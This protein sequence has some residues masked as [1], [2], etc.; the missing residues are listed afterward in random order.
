MKTIWIIALILGAFFSCKSTKC[1]T[2]KVGDDKKDAVSL[3]NTAWHLVSIHKVNIEEKIKL[4]YIQFDDSVKI[5]GFAGCNNFFGSYTLEGKSLDFGQLGLT[6]MFCEQTA[7]LENKFLKAIE[8][9]RS[10]E[11][12]STEFILY[13]EKKVEVLHFVEKP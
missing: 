9:V 5:S 1:C 12:N 2:K 13:D 6:R 8:E 4:P 11:I 7:E 3:T 10:F